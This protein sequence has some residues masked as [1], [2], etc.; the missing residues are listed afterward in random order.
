VCPSRTSPASLAIPYPQPTH[1]PQF[2]HTSFSQTATR[3][4]HRTC[5]PPGL[6]SLPPRTLPY[7]MCVTTTLACPPPSTLGNRP[8]LLHT[9]RL[10]TEDFRL[11]P[12]FLNHPI[13]RICKPRAR[14]PHVGTQHAQLGGSAV[15]R[16]LDTQSRRHHLPPRTQTTSKVSS[17]PPSSEDDAERASMR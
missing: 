1:H 4:R 6:E 5:R 14:L 16:G 11:S 7:T 17:H 10:K 13:R 3:T 2:N 12:E 15:G 9:V 8:S